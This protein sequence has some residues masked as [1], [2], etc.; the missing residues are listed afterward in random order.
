MIR[1]ACCVL[2]VLASCRR[3]R[4]ARAA[5]RCR[6]GGRGVGSASLAAARG[7]PWGVAW[8]ERRPGEGHR[9]AAA[10]VS[11][12]RHCHCLYNA[13][14]VACRCCRLVRRRGRGGTSNDLE[15]EHFWGLLLVSPPFVRE[16]G[17]LKYR[18]G[19]RFW[20]SLPLFSCHAG[21][22]GELPNISSRR[23]F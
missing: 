9:Q 19:A 8:E 22:G 10:I 14:L 3:K 17:I 1:D 21:E 13:I 15:G 4:A 16:E 18:G 5:G 12:S 23:A 7:A 20:S 2:L 6:C 11:R